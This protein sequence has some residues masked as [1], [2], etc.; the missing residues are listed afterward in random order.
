MS[1]LNRAICVLLS[2]SV[3]PGQV[4]VQS[5]KTG[6]I[7]LVETGGFHGDEVKAKD[8]EKLLGLCIRKKNE[9]RVL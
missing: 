9:N 6:E 5:A 3:L 4:F 2:L 1:M 8:G 7:L